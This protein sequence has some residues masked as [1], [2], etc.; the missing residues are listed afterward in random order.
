MDGLIVQVIGVVAVSA[1]SL[2]AL[3]ALA[4]D[5]ASR[6]TEALFERIEIR[7]ALRDRRRR[8]AREPELERVAVFDS[9]TNEG[10]HR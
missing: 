4:P 1:L 6:I 8:A 3:C 9:Y 5:T 7:L 10:A 2:P